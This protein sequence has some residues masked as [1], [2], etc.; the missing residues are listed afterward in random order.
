MPVA[1]TH[2]LPTIIAVPHPTVRRHLRSRRPTIV[3]VSHSAMQ[4]CLCSRLPAIVAVSHSTVQR[5]L[6]SWLPTIVPRSHS[7]VRMCVGSRLL[8]HCY[9]LPLTP[10][11]H[12]AASAPASVALTAVLIFPVLTRVLPVFRSRRL[13][14]IFAT[15]LDRH[16][17]PCLLTFLAIIATAFSSFA[18]THVIH[19]SLLLLLAVTFLLLSVPVAVSASATAS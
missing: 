13:R 11:L 7:T 6:R 2:A 15:T 16:R 4:R 5:Y 3:A 10:I 8:L 17:P 1:R 12:S 14:S 18:P 19:F 9:R